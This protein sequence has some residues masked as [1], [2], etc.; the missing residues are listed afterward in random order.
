MQITFKLAVDLCCLKIC[1]SVVRMVVK[2]LYSTWAKFDGC[3]YPVIMQKY[4]PSVMY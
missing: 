3:T 1:N 4:L 2:G